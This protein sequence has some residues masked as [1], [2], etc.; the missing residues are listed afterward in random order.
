MA[1]S[2]VVLAVLALIGTGFVGVAALAPGSLP[3]E[4]SIYLP[5]RQV[6]VVQKQLQITSDHLAGLAGDLEKIRQAQTSQ[7]AAIYS[8][9]TAQQ[10]AA[11][12]IASAMDLAASKSQDAATQQGAIGDLR[13]ANATMQRQITELQ[14]AVA[15]MRRAVATTL[16]SSTAAPAKPLAQQPARP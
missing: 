1:R 9:T 3:P 6:Q 16:T 8:L 4:F 7:A 13:Q 5:A 11:E 14:K 10:Q 2:A 12:R 15:G